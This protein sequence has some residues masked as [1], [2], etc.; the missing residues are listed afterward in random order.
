L[1]VAGLLALG[2]YWYLSLAGF[3]KM[4]KTS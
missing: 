4:L 3:W 1:V 2:D